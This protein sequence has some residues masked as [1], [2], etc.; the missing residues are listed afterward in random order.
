M[1]KQ[2]LTLAAGLA[3]AL[4]VS[5]QAADRIDLPAY[6]AKFPD[7]NK[8][9]GIME[10]GT[11]VHFFSNGNVD[12]SVTTPK[13]GKY[14]LGVIAS[15]KEAKGGFAEFKV[16]VDGRVS[17]EPIKLKTADRDD[18]GIDLQLPKGK[19]KITITFTNDIFADGE[20]DRNL[21]VHKAML[22]PR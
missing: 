15:C 6:K 7:N 3:I 16:S 19:V 22:T 12:W 14:R 13:A 4:A 11:T 8:H 17:G 18:Y 21:Y 10:D 2:I 1:K 5:A 9:F 20:Y